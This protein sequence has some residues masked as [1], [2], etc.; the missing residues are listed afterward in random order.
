MP[1]DA[2]ERAATRLEYHDSSLE[3]LAWL[4]PS[5]LVATLLIDPVWNPEL[6]KGP[7]PWTSPE[8]RLHFRK[9]RNRAEIDRRL[10]TLPFPIYPID[11]LYS[12]GRGVFI[13]AGA[14]LSEPLIITCE[15]I[16]EP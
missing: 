15:S 2:P 5:E 14:L 8:A 1:H 7:Q 9:V 10:A 12:G 13:L 4:R 3:S 16:H 11:G 6:R